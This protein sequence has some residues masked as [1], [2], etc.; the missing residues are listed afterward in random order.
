MFFLSPTLFEH[1]SLATSNADPAGT[2][3][4]QL[5]PFLSTSLSCM[6]S[7]GLLGPRSG[8]L[9]K[10]VTLRRPPMAS[11]AAIATRTPFY[12]WPTDTY[13]RRCTEKI[14]SLSWLGLS[15]HPAVQPCSNR[16][17]SS[18]SINSVIR[19]A[20]LW[21]QRGK[22]MFFLSTTFNLKHKMPHD[23]MKLH[24]V[25]PMVRIRARNTCSS[26]FPVAVI[27]ATG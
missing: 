20:L 6:K 10:N 5:Q 16:D 23:D 15:R 17:V 24:R 19:G 25:S 18:P 7:I 13:A 2:V 1:E 9:A 21:H 3:S 27:I 26:I 22:L 12:R 11:Y 8:F 4:D 14:P